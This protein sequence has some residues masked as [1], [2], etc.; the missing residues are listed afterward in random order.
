MFKDYTI[1]FPPPYLA[2]VDTGRTLTFHVN[3]LIPRNLPTWYCW[4]LGDCFILLILHKICPKVCVKHQGRERV[5]TDLFPIERL[6]KIALG[7]C[8]FY[9]KNLPKSNAYGARQVCR[10]KILRCKS[11]YL[12]P[13]VTHYG[14]C[15][16]SQC[17]KE[18]RRHFERNRPCPDSMEEVL[19]E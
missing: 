8:I 6:D 12:S 3:S 4:I 14:W 15:G 9:L 18:I 2:C 16:P 17:T 19:V 5:T 7:K 11:Q 10:K 13:T 1:F